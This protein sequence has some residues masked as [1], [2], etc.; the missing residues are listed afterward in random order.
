M[1]E[2]PQVVGLEAAGLT[3]SFLAPEAVALEGRT[4]R[5]RPAP[6]VDRPGTIAPAHPA[7][8]WYLIAQGRRDAKA[9]SLPRT[10]SERQSSRCYIVAPLVELELV[11]FTIRT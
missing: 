6:A 5:S 9:T 1:L 10:G 3:A 2:G 7:S 4:P 11:V 8:P